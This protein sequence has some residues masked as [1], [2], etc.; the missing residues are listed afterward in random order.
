VLSDLAGRGVHSKPTTC[1]VQDIGEHPTIDELQYQRA[2]ARGAL[3]T[4]VATLP[5]KRGDHP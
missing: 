2:V 3:N 4:R 1:S 5:R